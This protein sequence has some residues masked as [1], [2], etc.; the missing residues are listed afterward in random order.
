MVSRQ[1]FKKM[2]KKYS[3]GLWAVSKGLMRQNKRYEAK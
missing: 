3:L 1:K 2:M